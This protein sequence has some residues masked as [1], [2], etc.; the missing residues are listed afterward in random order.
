MQV[1][2][3][4]F[5]KIAFSPPIVWLIDWLDR[6]EISESLLGNQGE[7][8]AHRYL[9]SLGWIILER[10]YQDKLGEIDLIGV[11]GRTVVF[12]EVKTRSNDLSEPT[13]SVDE[14]K[15]KRIT[16]AAKAY[17]KWHGLTEKSCRFDVI[18]ITWPK[19]QQPN[20]SSNRKPGSASL[21]PKLKHYRS[22]FEAHGLFQLY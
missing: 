6:R 1:C 4:A 19:C 10:H 16:R 5:Y 15:Q 2:R 20:P 13:E 8:L 22:A 14:E 12:V 21:S 17:V 9:L 11:D 3:A 7:R 18:A